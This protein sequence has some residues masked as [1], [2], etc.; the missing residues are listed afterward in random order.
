MK[1]WN[2]YAKIIVKAQSRDQAEEVAQEMLDEHMGKVERG[3]LYDNF[4]ERVEED[5]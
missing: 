3:E 5:V 4:I 2:V 1:T